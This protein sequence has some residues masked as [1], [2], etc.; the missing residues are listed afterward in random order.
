MNFDPV[1]AVMA[2]ISVYGLIGLLVVALAE[3]FVPV[4]PS[5]GLLLAVGIG[6]ADGVWSLSTAF[7]ATA[8]GNLS[9]CAVWFYAVRRLGDA[10]SAHL[11]DTVGRR[12]GMSAD[13]FKNGISSFRRN[14][15]ALAFALQLVPPV[16]PF[17]PAF[18]ALLR[19]N[20]RIFLTASA[21]GIA[22]WT[23]GS[24][25]L[26]SM[27]RTPWRRR[28]QRSSL[29]RFSAACSSWRS[30][31]FQSQGASGPAAPWRT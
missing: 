17:V 2:W 1:S 7:L 11:L 9:R 6:A 28:T 25:A 20:A 22:V 14:Q 29:V 19:G 21:A 4:L 30:P 13:P 24:S 16:K 5:Y 27:R 3:R 8:T 26:D 18:A 10:C 31:C 12:F 23:A 15:T